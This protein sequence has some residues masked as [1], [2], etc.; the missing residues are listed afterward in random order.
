MSKKVG[1]ELVMLV[2]IKNDSAVSIAEV[3]NEMRTKLPNYMIPK[4]VFF[5]KNLP[6]NSNGKLDRNECLKLA[7]TLYDT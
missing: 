5:I 2:E 7:Q 6:L 1:G 4:K 3:K